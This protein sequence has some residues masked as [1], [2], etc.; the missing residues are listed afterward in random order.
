VCDEEWRGSEDVYKN[1]RRVL[2]RVCVCELPSPAIHTDHH[3][4]SLT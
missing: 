2:A 1:R 3:M 4:I